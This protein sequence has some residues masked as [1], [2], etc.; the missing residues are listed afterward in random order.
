[1]S[2]VRDNFKR[3]LRPYAGDEGY[4]EQTKDYQNLR[5]SNHV[6]VDALIMPHVPR[7]Q[8]ESKRH[9]LTL[10]KW[11]SHS[12]RSAGPRP[13]YTYSR[14]PTE[15]TA[16]HHRAGRTAPQVSGKSKNTPAVA[17]SAASCAAGSSRLASASVPAG[18]LCNRRCDM[19][20][21]YRG[22][23]QCWHVSALLPLPIEQTAQSQSKP[24][25]NGKAQPQLLISLH[26][27][28]A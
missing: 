7:H 10:K 1:M 5:T 23:A 3:A 12:G 2:L 4:A 18:G 6:V 15:V 27:S 25:V 8:R 19:P 26:S 13:P 21:T 28:S 20:T 14:S 22:A 16:W 11:M 24:T 9:S 17:G